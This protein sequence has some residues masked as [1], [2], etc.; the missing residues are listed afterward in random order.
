MGGKKV[1]ELPKVCI[2][3]YS[4]GGVAKQY[5]CGKCGHLVAGDRQT[6][7]C[8]ASLGPADGALELGDIMRTFWRM[9]S[10]YRKFK[11]LL[12]RFFPNEFAQWTDDISKAM[13]S[14][15]K[16]A[17]LGKAEDMG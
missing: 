8:G 2:R 1:K 3:L 9:R 5:A 11:R 10:R 4:A 15:E 12:C 16:A 6:C 14:F 13:W 17:G 7:E